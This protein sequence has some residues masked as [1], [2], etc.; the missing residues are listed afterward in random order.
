MLSGLLCAILLLGQP[1]AAEP[2]AVVPWF[3]DAEIAGAIR[4]EAPAG[5]PELVAGTAGEGLRPEGPLALEGIPLSRSAGMVSLW[6]RPDW[7]GDDGR[8]HVILRVGDPASNGLLLEKSERNVLR[9]LMAS[10]TGSTAARADVS[11]WRP[12]EWHQIAISWFS[13]EGKPLGL[14][15]WIDRKAVAGPTVGT[16]TFFDPAAL[17][18]PR[19]VLGDETTEATVDELIVRRDLT[20]EGNGQLGVVTRDYF[21][22]APYER[23]AIEPD[24][25]FVPSDRR[26]IAGYTK[27]FGLRAG[28]ATLEPVTDFT[29]RYGCWG[30]FDAKPFIRWTTSDAAVAT[31]DANGLVTGVAP[32]ACTLTAEFRGMSDRYELE[33]TPVEQPDLDLVTVSQLPRYS[34]TRAKWA[35]APGD[36][37]ESVARILNMGFVE[38]PAGAEVRFEL[39]P[40]ADRDFVLDPEERPI[41]TETRTLDGPLAPRA[42]TEVRFAWAFPAEPVWVRVTVDPDNAVPELCEANNANADLSTARPVR[43][44]YTP[45]FLESCYTERKV[46]LVGSFSYYDYIRAN[47]R[48]ADLLLR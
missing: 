43:F 35:P 12:G 11:A 47:K 30:N 40:D 16:N 24:S 25:C 17:D 39:L 28:S 48:R 21:R 1:Q 20:A 38:A 31:V 36:T 34:R 19:L 15:L 37:V 2:V 14:P 22:A 32:G 13:R 26:V 23:V 6:I 44:G 27:Q 3:T 5:A 9:F 45:E 29:V 42:E 41:V 8:R 18:D 10:P 7:A 46:N 4:L 33:V